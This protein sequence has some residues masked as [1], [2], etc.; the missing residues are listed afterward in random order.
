MK[1]PRLRTVLLIPVVL[2][3]LLYVVLAFLRA[4]HDE[5]L[6]P[7]TGPV[8]AQSTVAIFGASG[9]AGDGILKA[10]LADPIVS[11]VHV[12][13]RRT[14]PRIEEGMRSGK[15][16]MTKHM[17]YLDYSAVHAQI[18]DVDAVFWAIG[19]S[20]FGVDEKTYGIIH[21]DFPLRF[22]TEWIDVSS[23]PNLVF[24]YISSSDISDDS[25]MMWARE[26]VR[27]EKAL[28]GF[29]KGKKLKVINYRPDYIGP[30]AEQAHLGQNILY[31]FFA[32]VGA[33]VRAK[34]IG[35]AMIEV[36]ARKSQFENGDKLGTIGII[37]HSDA[38]ER[39]IA[40]S[41]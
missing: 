15:V 25:S 20:S 28:T 30:T 10:A 24:H 6:S 7:I 5:P 35:Q 21:V 1:F 22:V 40:T 4:T 12:I 19:T 14:T 29:A 32:P 16:R 37:K 27:A 9:T 38:Y 13:T 2:F 39:R 36:T 3:A 23:R 26:K 33:A 34:Q 17:D 41:E 11:E 31:W 8:G 18:A